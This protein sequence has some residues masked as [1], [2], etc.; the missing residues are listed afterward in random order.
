M[1]EY[2]LSFVEGPTLIVTAIILILLLLLIGCLVLFS[3]KRRG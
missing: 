1:S 2:I 3:S